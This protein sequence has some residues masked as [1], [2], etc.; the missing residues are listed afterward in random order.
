MSTATGGS[1]APHG[2]ADGSGGATQ[3][4]IPSPPRWQLA[5]AQHPMYLLI[6]EDE[7][8]AERTPPWG[9]PTIERYIERLRDNLRLVEGNASLRVGFEWSG[10][11]LEL[12]AVDAPDVV[13]SLRRLAQSADVCFYNGT[14]SQPHLQVLTAE[15][16]LRQFELGRASYLSLGL[17]P[18]VTYLHQESS[19]HDQLPQLLRAF[20]YRHAVLPGFTVRIELTAGT[21]ELCYVESSGMRVLDGDDFLE[22]QGLDGTTLPMYMGLHERQD[23]PWR[24][25]EAMLG[26]L[27]VPAIVIDMPD[28]TAIDEAWLAHRPEQLVLLED[29]LDERLRAAPPRARARFWSGWSYLEGI[30]AEALIRA[31]RSICSQLW[32][33][34]GTQALAWLLGGGEPPSCEEAW[35]ALA[36]A[37]H[38]D[39]HC[40]C[41]PDLRRAAM[42]RL[43]ALAAELHRAEAEGVGAIAAHLSVPPGDGEAI[44]AINATPHPIRTMLDVPCEGGRIF[45]AAGVEVPAERAAGSEQSTRFL[46]KLSG[47]GYRVYRARRDGTGIT[48]AVSA[49]SEAVEF[50]NAT[51]RIVL[52]PDGVI[53][54]LQ[55]VGGGER[56]LERGNLLTGTDSTG[57]DTHQHATPAFIDHDNARWAASEQAA[58]TLGAD[59]GGAAARA[60]P[61]RFDLPAA[62]R[63]PE[64]VFRPEAAA[65]VR[66]TPLGLSLSVAGSLGAGIT[67]AVT[68]RCYHDLARLD[69]TWRLDCELASV[70]NFFDDDSK[71]VSRW[72]PAFDGQPAHDI[73]F[74]VVS[75]RHGRPFL[76][77]S[78]V[79]WSDERAGFALLHRG[80]PKH[81][82]AERELAML[83]AWGEDTDAFGNRDGLHRWFKP[84]DYRLQG[85][86]TL[87][88]A[89]FPHA[90]DWRNGVEEAARGYAGL[91]AALPVP[92]GDGPLPSELALLTIED[93]AVAA[94][95]V[96]VADGRLTVNLFERLGQQTRVK[97]R[98]ARL[99][100]ATLSS[101]RGETIA[102]LDPHQIGT[103]R[104]EPGGEEPGVPDVP[105]VESRR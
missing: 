11:E 22:W 87:E 2:D 9:E 90:G 104:F 91:A 56:L 94:T 103:L 3:R 37:Q 98:T 43:E 58:N 31:D 79:D 96:R 30:H 5:L 76:A 40:F 50:D 1:A 55:L 92:A 62:V 72:T 20:A 34:E 16:N 42:A 66:R 85:V 35:R 95:G 88:M 44:L 97:A 63:G 102:Q 80:T 101:L 89:L 75:E 39:V 8:C 59:A 64:R 68:V 83:L 105:A 52:Q 93:P 19:L 7:R 23:P 48:D 26:L 71:L 99:R 46:A 17:P 74:G 49:T 13:A 81:W 57:H 29:A 54:S 70:G 32:R 84:F 65:A 10:L 21:A 15:A 73:P 6:R 51:Y 86:H 18:P 45:D 27:R 100:R 67:A 41:G 53:D 25:R 78:W 82:S 14:Y 38:H 69:I 24:R 47:F 36:R 61:E 12:L 77:T 4:A 60:A 33:T 28:L